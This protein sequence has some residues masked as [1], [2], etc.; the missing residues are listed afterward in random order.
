MLESSEGAYRM[1]L[2]ITWR[3]QKLPSE[4][5]PKEA[6]YA[7]SFQQQSIPS[8]T[9]ADYNNPSP[10]HINEHLCNDN[11][12]SAHA[13]NLYFHQPNPEISSITCPVGKVRVSLASFL[14]SI[15]HRRVRS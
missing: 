9:A 2:N 11:T 1:R 3:K 13:H 7:L 14:T 12:S 4:H 10:T 5:L 6:R 15:T 8:S